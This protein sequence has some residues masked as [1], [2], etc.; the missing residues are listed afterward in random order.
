MIR[1]KFNLCEFAVVP[2]IPEIEDVLL[3]LGIFVDNDLR[4]SRTPAAE[5]Y[6]ERMTRFFTTAA[7]GHLY[8]TH[9]YQVAAEIAEW[10][11]DW[12][13]GKEEWCTHVASMVKRAAETIVAMTPED[14]EDHHAVRRARQV[15]EAS[16]A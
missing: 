4:P 5:E 1:T 12:D 8:G 16:A 10:T 6:Q 13:S 14:W 3:I 15:L 2:Q 7:S 9:T 11:C